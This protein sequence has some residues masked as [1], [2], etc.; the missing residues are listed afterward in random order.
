MD[1]RLIPNYSPDNIFQP[2]KN[3]V[4]GLTSAYPTQKSGTT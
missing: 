3:S 2:S 4:F 1:L